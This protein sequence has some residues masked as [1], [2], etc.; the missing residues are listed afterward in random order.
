MGITLRHFF[1]IVLATVLFRGALGFSQDL[2]PQNDQRAL[3]GDQIVEKIVF[4]SDT[5]NAEVFARSVVDVPVGKWLTRDEL[6]N[7]IVRTEQHLRALGYFR[8]IDLKL[9]RGTTPAHFILI[10][11]TEAESLRYFGVASSV[12]HTKRRAEYEGSYNKRS[13]FDLFGGTRNLWGT[14]FQFDIDAKYSLAD[15]RDN[16]HFNDMSAGTR[17]SSREP[18][19]FV[20]LNIP[21]VAGSPVFLSTTYVRGQSF[22]SVNQ[23]NW[24]KDQLTMIGE[25]S[26]HFNYNG[27]FQVVGLRFGLLRASF[28]LLRIL[29][30][31]GYNY[32]YDSPEGSPATF[33]VAADEQYLFGGTTAYSQLQ[34][35]EKTGLVAIEP[36]MLARVSMQRET[37][38]NVN[39]PY[40]I[41]SVEHSSLFAE[42]HALTPKGIAKWK[43]DGDFQRDYNISLR[44]EYA[45]PWTWVI[46]AE[47]GFGRRF[48]EPGS[49]HNTSY[50]QY[51]TSLSAKYYT[52]SFIASLAFIYG[53]LGIATDD[54]DISSLS[55]SVRT[56]E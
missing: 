39:V 26:S 44:Y 42:R 31:G 15:N 13:Y 6:D 28:G 16:Y 18:T 40:Y 29:G 45:T 49:N 8:N 32:S 50:P 46:G 19:I 43:R 17:T 1:L 11:T 54:F 34:Y 27:I 47:E 56:P 51:H 30:Q 37:A 24:Y 36:G 52:P 7:A 14:G 55:D 53:D 4:N 2:V 38:G 25:N 12:R 9:E 33:H 20:S 41:A 35:S 10:V 21:D 22:Y 48:Q 5:K 3:L 23:T